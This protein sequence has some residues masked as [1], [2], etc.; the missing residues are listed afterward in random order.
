MTS[1]AT[2]VVAH[3]GELFDVHVSGEAERGAVLLL[4]GFPGGSDTWDGWLE[5]LHAVA[6][7]TIAPA[8]R[9]DGAGARPR[10]VSAYRIEHLV[11]DAAAAGPTDD[12]T[13]IVDVELT[14][15]RMRVTVID[16]G[17]WSDQIVD[18][19]RGRGLGVVEHLAATSSQRSSAQGTIA[20][21]E[22]LRTDHATRGRPRHP[23]SA[24]P[25]RPALPPA[26]VTPT[27]SH[28]SAHQ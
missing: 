14:T 16:D 17:R 28:A 13:V 8:R 1:R 9:G 25:P 18:A 2:V 5:R 15:D 26:S 24:G 11:D 7:R 20:R 3:D 21:I 23:G 6:L 4:H 10:P 19:A 12:G 22:V 27:S